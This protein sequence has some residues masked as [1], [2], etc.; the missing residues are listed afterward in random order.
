VKAVMDNSGEDDGEIESDDDNKEID[1][2]DDGYD[3]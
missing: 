2:D 3:E 1:G